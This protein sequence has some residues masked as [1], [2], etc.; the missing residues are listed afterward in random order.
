VLFESA[1]VQKLNLA[2]SCIC[3]MLVA[4]VVYVLKFREANWLTYPEKFGWFKALNISQR[5]WNVLFSVILNRLPK[6]RS[7]SV[8]PASRRFV[9]PARPVL[10]KQ[11]LADGQLS[12]LNGALRDRMQ[13]A[14]IAI[15][16]SGHH[17]V[18]RIRRAIQQS[19]RNPHNVSLGAARHRVRRYGADVDRCGVDG[20]RKARLDGENPALAPAIQH[21]LLPAVEA[22]GERD[23]VVVRQYENGLRMSN[24]ELERWKA[25]ALAA[26]IRLALS[27]TRTLSAFG[28]IVQAVRP[29]VVSIEGQP[30]L[31]SADAL[32]LQSVVT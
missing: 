30:I 9:A 17:A 31:K 4:V 26:S 18:G 5:S 10:S 25:S 6:A 14:S 28:H 13:L 11:R 21:V 19:V 16:G 32:Q 20:G 24:C 1:I 29:S 3:R 2:L 27:F 15:E 8:S 23:F 7:R 12:R 22:L